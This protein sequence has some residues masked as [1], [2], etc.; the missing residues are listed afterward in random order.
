MGGLGQVPGGVH[1]IEYAHRL[2]TV[3]VEQLLD[4]DRAVTER[5]HRARMG[6]DPPPCQFPEHGAAEGGGRG[7]LADVTERRRRGAVLGPDDEGPGFRPLAVHERHHRPIEFEDRGLHRRQGPGV[8]HSHGGGKRCPGRR[9]QVGYQRQFQLPPGI[10]GRFGKAAHGIV[11]DPR[12]AGRGQQR[13][14]TVEGA[15]Q[16]KAHREGRQSG[17]ELA[18]HQRQLVSE[19]G[20]ARPRRPG[21]HT[22]RPSGARGPRGR[23]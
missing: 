11:G 5:H 21:K 4:P 17:G 19:G 20:K 14:R 12:P 15:G 13:R 16:A 2:G 3:Q 23:S 6:G 22:G 1:D 8:G 18:G 7:E 9:L 10:P